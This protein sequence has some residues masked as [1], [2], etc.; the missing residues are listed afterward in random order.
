MIR[1]DMIWYD[2]IF[3]FFFIYYILC[4]HYFSLLR[5]LYIIFAAIRRR[6]ARDII[7]IFTLHTDI[8]AF[9][10]HIFIF[11]L[12]LPWYDMIYDTPLFSTTPYF[13][14]RLPFLRYFHYYYAFLY[15]LLPFCLWARL[16][17][18]CYYADDYFHYKILIYFHYYFYDIW[19]MI[20]LYEKIIIMRT[21]FFDF[22]DFMIYYIKRCRLKRYYMILW[23]YIIILYARR[24]A[25]FRYFHA[26]CLPYDIMIYWYFRHATIYIFGA[27][28]S[29]RD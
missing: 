22:Y 4:F 15:L 17:S 29:A 27:L 1:Y 7:T 3:A 18:L 28:F 2:I 12:L 8:Y 26:F 14:I 24:Y 5:Y 20:L 23:W 16:F 10:W 21:P 25:Y 11:S 13:H 19:Y 6:R 9:W